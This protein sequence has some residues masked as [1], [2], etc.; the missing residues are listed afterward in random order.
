MR[1][2]EHIISKSIIGE[3]NQ[4]EKSKLE[5]WISSHPDNSKEYEA[6]TELWNKSKK[7]VLSDSINV[8]AS[9][10]ET[11][12]RIN[13]SG[14]N[15]RWS[16]LFKQVAAVLILSVSFSILYNYFVIKGTNGEIPEQIVYQEIKVAYGTQTKIILADGTNVWLNS[17]S[18]LRFPNS[19]Q[20]ANER[21]VDL[22]GEGFFEVTKNDTKPFIVNTSKLDVKVYGTSFNVS[23]YEDYNTMNV[24]LVEGKVSLI[25]KY[26]NEIKELIVLNPNEVVEYN[27]NEKKLYHS[28]D[29]NYMQKYI[30][31]KEGQI[32]F[33]G[34][35]INRVIERLEKWYNVDINITDNALQNYS[36]TA[37][38]IDESLEQVLKLLC[39]SSQMQC[40]I[41]PAQK[42]SDNSF[43]KRKVTFSINK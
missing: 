39:L 17:G 40:T 43:R 11:K 13:L 14:K 3:L 4:E 7:L 31:W 42:L 2:I 25:K 34:D 10:A 23:A 33:Y 32:V 36:F 29:N 6:Y 24:A 19:F 9:L 41:A 22:N 30:A 35:P 16:V 20:K 8:E 1:K 5:E 26:G 27:I 38:F 21:K 28:A 37:T 18:T 12:K 15:R